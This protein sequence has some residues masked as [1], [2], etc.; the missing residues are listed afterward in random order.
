MTSIADIHSLEIASPAFLGPPC[1][2]EK[3][4]CKRGR[5]VIALAKG[6]L[7]ADIPFSIAGQVVLR[8]YSARILM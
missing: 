6:D 7:P 1:P 5:V 4:S 2:I 3:K 8:E